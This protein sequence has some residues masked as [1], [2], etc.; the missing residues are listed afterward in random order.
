MMR[1]CTIIARN[2][3]AHARVLAQTLRAHHP[4]ARLS[5]LV[6]DADAATPALGQ[7]EAFDVLTPQDIGIDR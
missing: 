3:W 5:V 4:D 2:Y 6:V 1:A 7:R